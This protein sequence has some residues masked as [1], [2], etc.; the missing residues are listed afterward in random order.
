MRGIPLLS[1]FTKFTI[2]VVFPLDNS[3]TNRIRQC[4][5][6]LALFP[7]HRHIELFDV[8]EAHAAAISSNVLI[9]YLQ[10]LPTNN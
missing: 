3:S 8:P 10:F 9:Y 5:K 4:H 6:P 1:G 7:K 2:G